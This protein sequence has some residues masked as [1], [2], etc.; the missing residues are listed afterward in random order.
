MEAILERKRQAQLELVN[1]AFAFRRECDGV[2]WNF[3]DR[4][5]K[6][7]QAGWGRRHLR[8][9][10]DDREGG[11][12]LSV[13][14][15]LG[16]LRDAADACQQAHVARR[17][18]VKQLLQ[19]MLVV[20]IQLKMPLDCY[21][22]SVATQ[23]LARRG[24]EVGKRMQNAKVDN[25]TLFSTGKIDWGRLGVYGLILNATDQLVKVQHRPT[26]DTCDVDPTEPWVTADWDLHENLSDFTAVLSIGLGEWEWCDFFGKHP[27]PHRMKMIVGVSVD[28]K[29]HVK[30]ALL[31]MTRQ[32]CQLEDPWV[33]EDQK[34]FKDAQVEKKAVMAKRARE[35]LVAR[36]QERLKKREVTIKAAA[37]TD[38]GARCFYRF[39]R[40]PSGVASHVVTPELS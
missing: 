9:A 4:V 35:A 23:A 32:L 8:R 20:S 24:A 18:F 7:K 19:Y 1:L 37:I 40:M 10:L 31:M 3:K 26:G 14:L 6:A 22:G 28:F 33:E 11:R 17:R 13:R 39:R 12:W 27:G 29:Q 2:V 5:K 36:Q 34:H 21:E 30:E 25:R 16:S 38:A 15:H